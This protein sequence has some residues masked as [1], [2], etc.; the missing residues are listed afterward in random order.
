MNEIWIWYIK[1][2]EIACGHSTLYGCQKNNILYIFEDRAPILKLDFLENKEFYAKSV[3][4]NFDAF[5]TRNHVLP[6]FTTNRK[7]KKTKV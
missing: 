3:G 1:M 5:F 6:N 4:H 2:H 7:I